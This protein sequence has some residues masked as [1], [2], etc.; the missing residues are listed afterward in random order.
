MSLPRK[1][2]NSWNIAPRHT[3]DFCLDQL[4]QRNSSEA[5]SSG[6]TRDSWLLL[7]S[8]SIY[9]IMDPISPDAPLPSPVDGASEAAAVPQL[10]DGDGMKAVANT[11]A[12][13]AAAAT[14]LG[15]MESRAPPSVSSAC[16]ACVSWCLHDW[17]H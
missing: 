6:A 17:L 9:S 4:A 15:P 14:S 5:A 2:N 11:N 10:G 1:N 12:A 3:P 7:R 16:L 8:R 13:A